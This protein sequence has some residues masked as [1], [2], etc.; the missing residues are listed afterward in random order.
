MIE[1][2]GRE[3]A[4]EP[5]IRARMKMESDMLDELRSSSVVCDEEGQDMVEYTLLMAFLV[6]ASA[7]TLITVSGDINNLW[8]GISNRLANSN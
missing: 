1:D 7:A 2:P 4:S 3:V 8:T 6:L 5:P